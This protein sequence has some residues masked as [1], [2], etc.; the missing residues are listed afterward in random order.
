M[1]DIENGQKTN[2]KWLDALPP[3]HEKQKMVLDKLSAKAKELSKLLGFKVEP[4]EIRQ[5]EVKHIVNQNQPYKSEKQRAM[6]E[7]KA[8]MLVFADY[9][10][11]DNQGKMIPQQLSV[12]PYLYGDVIDIEEKRIILT[13]IINRIKEGL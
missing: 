12:D 3:P 10:M 1:A 6:A 13:K 9:P 4:Y 5:M 8:Q 2:I 11:Y 7:I